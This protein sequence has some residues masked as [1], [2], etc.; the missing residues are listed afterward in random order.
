MCASLQTCVQTFGSGSIGRSLSEPSVVVRAHSASRS[1]F[2][3]LG[4]GEKLVGLLQRALQSPRA[5]IILPA[6]HQRRLELDRQDLLQDRD[7][8]VNQL[9]LQI[10]R[11]GRDDRLLLLLE[12]E[13]RSRARDR[14]AIC[15]RRCP[16]RPTRCRSSSSAR[17]IAT[18]ISCCCGRNS[19]L[20]RLREQPVLREN[21]PHPLDKVAPQRIFERNHSAAKLREKFEICPA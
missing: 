9:F 20:L 11:V 8:L 1:E 17:A 21:R 15:R 5:K 4:A 14:R 10:D 16:L 6:F 19:K 12:R 3:L 18:A 7:V 13:K 2:R